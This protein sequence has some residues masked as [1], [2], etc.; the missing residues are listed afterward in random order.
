MAHFLSWTRLCRCPELLTRG[1]VHGNIQ[2]PHGRPPGLCC[3]RRKFLDR[4]DIISFFQ[5][6]STLADALIGF[7]ES[8]RR[9]R[10]RSIFRTKSSMMPAKGEAR[11]GR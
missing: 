10:R 8:G 9:E 3:R 5:E 2:R 11:D 7:M 4:I 1:F 6:D